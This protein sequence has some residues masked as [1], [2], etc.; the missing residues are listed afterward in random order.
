MLFE[1][2]RAKKMEMDALV[3]GDCEEGCNAGVAT[4]VWL[5]STLSPGMPDVLFFWFLSSWDGGLLFL[6]LIVFCLLWFQDEGQQTMVMLVVHNLW[7]SGV[8]FSLQGRRQWQGWS[9]TLLCLSLVLCVYFFF[10]VYA[11]FF[12]LWFALYLGWFFRPCSVFFWVDFPP[13]F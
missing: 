6:S 3:S 4:L 2:R 11:L 1:H 9:V 8:F 7:F 13:W 5:F 10:W 12:F